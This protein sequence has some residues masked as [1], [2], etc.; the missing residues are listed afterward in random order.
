MDIVYSLDFAPQRSL[1]T[2][3]PKPEKQDQNPPQ[4][5]SA[6]GSFCS[7]ASPSLEAQ[8]G[9]WPHPVGHAFAIAH[10]HPIFDGGRERIDRL[11]NGGFGDGFRI[12]PI[13]HTRHPSGANF[14]FANR[15][16]PTTEGR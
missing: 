7:W 8:P 1:D 12:V 5:G 9:R 4:F 10:H 11:A 13:P 3:Y 2:A 15:R 16:C 14:Q 6:G